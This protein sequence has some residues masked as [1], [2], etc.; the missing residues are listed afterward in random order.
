MMDQRSILF[1]PLVMQQIFR[2]K[3]WTVLG[4]WHPDSVM[5]QAMTC[6]HSWIIL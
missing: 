1:D 4:V 5:N 6:I 3:N 2:R